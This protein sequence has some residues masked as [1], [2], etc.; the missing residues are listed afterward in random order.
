MKHATCCKPT[1]VQVQVIGLT[2]TIKFVRCV[3]VF[4]L[5]EFYSSFFTT[6]QSLDSIVF[7][8]T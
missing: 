1:G 3:V 2:C 8:Y 6:V 4:S 7:K 5:E